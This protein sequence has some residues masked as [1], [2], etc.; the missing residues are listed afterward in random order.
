MKKIIWFFLFIIIY[1]FAGPANVLAKSQTP[2]ESY[3]NTPSSPLTKKLS[4]TSNSAQPKDFIQ[5]VKKR[6]AE[7]RKSFTKQKK[8]SSRFMSQKETLILFQWLNEQQISLQ[9]A[10]ANITKKDFNSKEGF[11]PELLKKEIHFDTFANDRLFYLNFQQNIIQFPYILKWGLRASLGVAFNYDNDRKYFFP[12]S[13]SGIW[14]LQIF[15]HQII[16][17]FFEMG[18]S[19]WNINS[20]LEEF[21]PL[22]PFWGVGASISL[23]LFK[24]S[25]RYTLPD[26]YGIKD[27]GIILEF[28]RHSSPLKWLNPWFN[29]E[30]KEWLWPEEKRGYFF[31]SFHAGIYCRF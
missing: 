2:A 6:I 7:G 23:A 25:L 17:P 20:Y 18:F 21:T 26:E 24:N 12:M 31:D 13:A 29:S 10:G 28:R 22:F 8:P 15:K 3:Q 27:L 5:S 16:I 1:V 11:A 4:P 9:W 30:K 14:S 19:T